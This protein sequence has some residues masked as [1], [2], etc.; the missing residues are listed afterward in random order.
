MN[1]TD[2]DRLLDVLYDMG[3]EYDRDDNVVTVVNDEGSNGLT[4]VFNS[5]GSLETVE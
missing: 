1:V 5:S 3:I 2:M 4:F